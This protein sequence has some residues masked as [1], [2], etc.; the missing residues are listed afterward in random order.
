[1]LAPQMNLVSN[2]AKACRAILAVMSDIEEIDVLYNGVP[3][4]H[5][6]IT[7]EEVA[8]VPSFAAAGITATTVADAIYQL[9]QVRSQIVN[10]NLPAMIQ[11]KVLG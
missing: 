10:G 7:N 8:S 6:L 5:T 9:N 3:D 2:T 1:M 4:W 11:M